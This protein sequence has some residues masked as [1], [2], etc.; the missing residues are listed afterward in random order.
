MHLSGFSLQVWSA[1]GMEIHRILRSS[2]VYKKRH[3]RHP[4]LIKKSESIPNLVR[5]L[6][7]VKSSRLTQ[8]AP[9]NLLQALW[10]EQVG[11][12][13]PRLHTQSEVC[14]EKYLHHRCIQSQTS[15]HLTNEWNMSLILWSKS[16]SYLLEYHCVAAYSLHP[17]TVRTEIT[18]HHLVCKISVR[19]PMR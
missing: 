8:I 7:Y 6:V 14:K 1:R 5:P 4:S 13:L 15:C 10:S 9:I 2:Q 16:Q 18:R 19:R 3:A 17:G 12:D 11:T